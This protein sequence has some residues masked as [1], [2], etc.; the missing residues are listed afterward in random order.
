MMGKKAQE[1][2]SEGHVSSIFLQPNAFLGLQ[3]ELAE[4]FAEARGAGY[5]IDASRG[6][7]QTVECGNACYLYV[8][9]LHA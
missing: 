5:I 3:R 6:S 7:I 1:W 4:G 9:G 2:Q 8:A